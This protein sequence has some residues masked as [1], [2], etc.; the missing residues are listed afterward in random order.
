MCNRHDPFPLS[1]PPTALGQAD[2]ANLTPPG[3]QCE[4]RSAITCC[5]QNTPCSFCDVPLPFPATGMLR[6]CSSTMSMILGG[7]S[8][9]H[10][11]FGSVGK[12]CSGRSQPCVLINTTSCAPKDLDVAVPRFIP[13]LQQQDLSRGA[14]FQRVPLNPCRSP[15][16][17]QAH[18]LPLS[19]KAPPG[20]LLPCGGG[21]STWT[22]WMCPVISGWHIFSQVCL[23]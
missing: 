17:P 18:P 3:H 14:A 1:N 21:F 23:C 10:H 13:R 11:A 6:N 12:N 5:Q 16:L 9:S 19:Q 22:A 8:K 20:W 4:S 15:A 7:T 2:C